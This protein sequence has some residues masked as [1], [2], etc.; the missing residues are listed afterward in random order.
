[1]PDIPNIDLSSLPEIPAQS[2]LID[3]AEALRYLRHPAPPDK[4]LAAALQEAA[5]AVRAA[6]APRFVLH[7]FPIE[8]HKPIKLTGTNLRLTG[9][10]IEGLLAPAPVCLLMAATLGAQVD[11]LIRRSQLRDMARA[12]L[13]DAAA[14][15]AIESLCDQLQAQIQIRCINIKPANKPGWG[16]TRRFSPGYADLPLDT[17]APL[18]AALDAP[19]RIGLTVSRSGLLLPRKSVT[20]IIGLVPV[21]APVG[22][23]QNHDCSVCSMAETCPYRKS[24]QGCPQ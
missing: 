5:E 6:A 14:S 3:E 1:M 24:G 23:G 19:R 12:L 15:C 17:S 9:A 13:L 18:C 16:L 10:A 11:E 20:A 4:S 8:G 21:T 2:L 22:P 7:S